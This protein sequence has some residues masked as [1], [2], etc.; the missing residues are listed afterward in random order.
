M[1]FA[2]P[3]GARA[4][5]LIDVPSPLSGSTNTAER[6]RLL[7]ALHQEIRACQL[8]VLAGYLAEANTVAGT[9]GKIGHRVMIVGQAP[10]HLSVEQ[11]KPFSGPGG[12]ILDQWLQRAGFAAGALHRE[13]YISAV[14]RC[15]PGKNPRGGGDR[16]P[17]PPEVALCRPYLLR[18]LEL[19]RPQALLPV[20]GMAISAFLGP[21]R[22][23]DVVGTSFERNGVHILPLPH[24]SGVSRWLNDSEHQALLTQGLALL[25]GWRRSW[26]EGEGEGL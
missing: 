20:G 2:S 5:P 19:V 3:Q 7:A 10:G 12:R 8:C 18:E 4:L 14:T 23:E 21:S 24:P 9:R 17:S 1:T 26:E 16:K 13:V 11:G 15:D 25:D 22:L 6:E